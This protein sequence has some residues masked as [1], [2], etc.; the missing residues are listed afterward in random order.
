MDVH[1][2][3][4]ELD[5]PVRQVVFPIEPITFAIPKQGVTRKVVTLPKWKNYV[6]NIKFFLKRN[7]A[8]AKLASTQIIATKVLEIVIFQT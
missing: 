5:F 3:R 8:K 4:K 6:E 7:T 1:L 2:P